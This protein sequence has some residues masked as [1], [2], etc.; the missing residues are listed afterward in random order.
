MSVNG[1]R[2]KSYKRVSKILSALF[3]IGTF[4]ITSCIKPDGEVRSLSNQDPSTATEAISVTATP[5]GL[6]TGLLLDMPV[7]FS[8]P[9]PEENWTPID[10][11]YA[12]LDPSNPQWW[13]CR[14]CADYRPAGGIWK[15]Q[16]NKGVM[17]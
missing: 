14:R 15:L 9:L 3:L 1:T 17:M 2:M 13:A 16:F 12:K 8:T 10:G 6:W 5:T 11:T 4:L 7:A